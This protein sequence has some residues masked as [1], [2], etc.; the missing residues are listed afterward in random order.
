M[1]PRKQTPPA[2][3]H[4][5]SACRCWPSATRRARISL[6]LSLSIYIY[7]YIYIYISVQ[8]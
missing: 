1:A 6:S 7:I 5:E 2:T 4:P 3:F 8:I